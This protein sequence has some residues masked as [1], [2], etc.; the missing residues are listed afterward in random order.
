M[1]KAIVLGESLFA[2]INLGSVEVVDSIPITGISIVGADTVMLGESIEYEVAYTPRNTTY[3]GVIW[4]VVDSPIGI[5]VSNDGTVAV[6]TSATVASFT[7][8]ATSVHDASITATKTVALTHVIGFAFNNLLTGNINGSNKTSAARQFC[9]YNSLI[10]C[11]K[12]DI[13]HVKFPVQK[14]T[15]YSSYFWRFKFI[16]FNTKNLPTNLMTTASLDLTSYISIAHTYIDIP[17][18]KDGSE[19]TYTIQGDDTVCVYFQF[20]MRSST[21]DFAAF[22][23]S[24]YGNPA[25]NEARTNWANEYSDEEQLG[26]IEVDEQ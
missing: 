2:D 25:N 1:G 17:W 11:K 8:K 7:I 18:D 14:Q 26:Y 15:S 5:S 9:H 23:S 22:T 4:E 21:T 13:I 20:D 6:G 16:E 19:G 24:T 3:K 12:G 10:E